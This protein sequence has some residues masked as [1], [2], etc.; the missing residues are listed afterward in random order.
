M[1]TMSIIIL[2]EFWSIFHAVHRSAQIGQHCSPKN[3]FRH[4]FSAVC[5]VLAA[6]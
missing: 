5:V 1:A 6:A 3:L 2:V 4:K